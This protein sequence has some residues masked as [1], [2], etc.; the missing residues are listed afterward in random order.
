MGEAKGADQEAGTA[1]GACSSASASAA[2]TLLILEETLRNK[3]LFL[4]KE[5]ALRENQKVAFEHQQT[6]FVEQLAA[7]N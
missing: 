3:K 4:T 2:E 5:Q 7:I 1:H 6:D